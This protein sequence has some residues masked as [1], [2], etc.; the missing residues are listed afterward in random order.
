MQLVA[1]YDN[2]QDSLLMHVGC[3]QA[4]PCLGRAALALPRHALDVG[5]IQR[6][7]GPESCTR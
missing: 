6:V 1:T 2:M 3:M 5:R 4:A 7:D